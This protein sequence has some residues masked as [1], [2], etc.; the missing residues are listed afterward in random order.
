MS[1]LGGMSLYITGVTILDRMVELINPPI[2]TIANGAISGF[3]FRAMGSSPHMAV[4]EVSTT[5]RKRVS[6]AIA[7]AS[8]ML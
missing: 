4:M 3:G 7:M 8:S 6:P 5:G 1:I 2:N